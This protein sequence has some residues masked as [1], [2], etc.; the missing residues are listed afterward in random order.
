MERGVSKAETSFS[1][2]LALSLNDPTVSPGN[3]KGDTDIGRRQQLSS[4]PLIIRIRGGTKRC[5]VYHIDTIN[6]RTGQLKSRTQSQAVCVAPPRCPT[7]ASGTGHKVST[8]S[9]TSPVN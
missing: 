7:A 8:K 2:V 4:L 9:M 5:G 6:W 3:S 1:M